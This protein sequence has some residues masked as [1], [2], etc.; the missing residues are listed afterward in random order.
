MKRN[1]LFAAVA[2]VAAL[3]LGVTQ[4]A[5][6]D[7]SGSGPEF[8]FGASV[9]FGYDFNDPDTGNAAQNR[10]GYS[11]ME[12]DE[13]FNIDL[14]QLG[15]NGERGAL[16]YAGTLDF[17]DLAAF[18]GDSADGD[19]ALQ[20]MNITY[21]FGPVAATAGRFATPIGYEVL[22]PWGNAHISRSR[23]WQAQPINH[24]GI[25]VSGS[26]DVV[27]WMLGVANNFTVADQQIAAND[28]DD[29]KAIIASIGAPLG[30]DH[31]A[32]LSGLYTQEGD[33]LDI[34]MLNT[35]F[36]GLIPTGD[37]D[38]NYALEGN[39]RN[40]DPDIGSEL[41]LW[42]IAAYGGVD[43]GP[44][45]IDLRVDY[46]DDEGIVSP[47][48]AEVT[49]VTVTGSIPLASGVDVRLEYRFDT[50]NEDIFGDGS[51]L[52]DTMNTVQAQLV[53]APEAN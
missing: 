25:T 44:G 2:A 46:T 9:S 29:E 20:T 13:S 40:N 53:W 50:S 42:N 3:S 5:I 34:W 52:E 1:V 17:G 41:Q 27:D 26:V 22:E 37:M 16:S 24:D 21:D 33:F 35:I 47:I 4:S 6:A 18:A 51:S 7:D 15:I 49:S 28:V 10:L 43:V 23:G 38:I 11:S 30:D 31:S 48:D 14:V 8:T 19:I 36:A 45:S 12:Q 39:L 32:Y